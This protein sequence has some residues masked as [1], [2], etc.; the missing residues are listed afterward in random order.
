[1]DDVR[2]GIIGCGDVT[3]VK[4]GPGLRLAEGSEL[5]AVMRRD[6][7]RARDYAER[8]GVPRW[9]DDASA[10]IDDDEVNA[11]YIATPPDSHL[12]YT[13]RV[14]AAGNPVYVEKP[15]ARTA[16]ECERMVQACAD[17]DVPL[18]VAYYRRRLPLFLK[19]E[20]LLTEGA[21]GAPRYV[22]IRHLGVFGPTSGD[23]A[24]WRVVPEIAGKGGYFHDLASHQFDL[25]D[26]LLGPVE[27]AAG[28]ALNLGGHYACDDTITAAWR[29]RSGA[30]GVGS[31]CFVAGD[32]LLA[33]D[34]E[35]VGSAG[36]IGFTAFDLDRPL[37][38]QRGGVTEE[39]HLPPP[40]H[41][42]QPLIQSV[43]DD[44]LGRGTCPS[45]GASAL[46][47]ARVMDQILGVD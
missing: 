13:E 37:R 28:V 19:A 12:K 27:P 17:A 42:Q 36:R 41:V 40:E 8:H 2:W 31:W 46:R 30:A 15:M 1:M 35:V 16:A 9:Y 6:G 14:A 33:E 32:G 43:V 26:Y 39:F 21:I 47:T 5:V 20:S 45:P 18:F 4:S 10:L 34:I 7:A 22:S 11:V 44:L 24:P 23:G 3:E 25:L 38:L 29:H